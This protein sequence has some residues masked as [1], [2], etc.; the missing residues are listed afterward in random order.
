MRRVL[1]DSEE[2]RA[3]AASCADQANCA[4]GPSDRKVWIDSAQGWLDLAADIE[5]AAARVERSMR[6]IT[7]PGT[8]TSGMMFAA[9]SLAAASAL[10]PALP[11]S[12]LLWTISATLQAPMMTPLPPI[13]LTA[14]CMAQP[15][16]ISGSRTGARVSSTAILAEPSRNSFMRK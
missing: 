9:H 7:I 15:I 3:F 4:L 14:D 10:T 1:F 16:D 12:I 8:R 11:E 5:A 2:C 13:I 6:L